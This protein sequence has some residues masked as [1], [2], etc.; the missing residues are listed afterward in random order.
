MGYRTEILHKLGFELAPQTD[1]LEAMNGPE[2]GKWFVLEGDS[3]LLGRSEAA[4]IAISL[5]SSVSRQHAR[6]TREG[7]QYFLEDIGST[8]GTIVNGRVIEV[9]TK[10]NYAD[11]IIV[12]S[13]L[14][15]LRRGT[16]NL[17]AD[18]E[19]DEANEL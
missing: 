1:A 8:H 19:K 17:P 6:L 16:G 15:E 11:Q 14:L 10:L 18:E 12:G 13:T 3:W 9:K 4:E 2:D 7:D 5:D